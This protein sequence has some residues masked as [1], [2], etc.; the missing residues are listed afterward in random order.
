MADTTRTDGPGA[1]TCTVC[2]GIPPDLLVN[3]GRDG[4]FPGEVR[5]LVQLDLGSSNDL[6]RC[7]ECG[8][9]FEWEDLPQYYGSGNNDEE[10]LT[11]LDSAQA[12]TARDL[13]DPEP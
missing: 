10:R 5:R 1:P 12:S 9:L 8:A 11:R 13:L 4:T 3:T 7:P 6:Y 2:S